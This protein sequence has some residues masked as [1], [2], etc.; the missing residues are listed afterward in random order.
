MLKGNPPRGTP[1]KSEREKE[2]LKMRMVFQRKDFV[3]SVHSLNSRHGKIAKESPW[4]TQFISNGSPNVDPRSL[5]IHPSQIKLSVNE[6][7]QLPHCPWNAIIDNAFAVVA[8]Q[9]IKLISIMQQV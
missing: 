2:G 9:A 6:V 7:F 8:S 4:A 5:Q 1:Q 3:L